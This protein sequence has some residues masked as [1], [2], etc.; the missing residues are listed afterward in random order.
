MYVINRVCTSIHI[1]Y[2]RYLYTDD[3]P[4]IHLCMYIT[5]AYTHTYKRIDET[6]LVWIEIVPSTR[7]SII[8]TTPPPP[9][10]APPPSRPPTYLPKTPKQ[11]NDQW[12]NRGRSTTAARNGLPKTSHARLAVYIYFHNARFK[13]GRVRFLPQFSGGF[14]RVLTYIITSLTVMRYNHQPTS[15]EKLRVS[16]FIRLFIYLH[17]LQNLDRIFSQPGI[18][19]QVG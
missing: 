19:N 17:T 15:H 7:V 14:S 8:T 12:T 2:T 4:H 9:S 18:G 6:E 1:V 10:S 13:L 5:R 11:Y 16:P 3:I